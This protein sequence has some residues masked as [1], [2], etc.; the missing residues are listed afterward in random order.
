MS[1]RPNLPKNPLRR[2]GVSQRQRLTSALSPNGANAVQVDERNLADFLVL[3]HRLSPQVRYHR[4]PGAAAPASADDHWQGFFEAYTPVQIALISKTQTRTVKREYDG[5]LG[6]FLKEDVQ[7]QKEERLRDI[8][9]LWQTEI[10]KPID[11][12][13]KGLESYTPLRSVIKGLINTNLTET[14]ALILSF[15][16]AH[17]SGQVDFYLPFIDAFGLPLTPA[18]VNMPPLAPSLF[19]PTIRDDLDGIFQSLFQVY[20]QIIDQAPSYLATSLSARRDH[21]PHLALYI[22]M[23]DVLQPARDDLNRMTQRHLDFFYRRVLALPARPATP[24]YVHLLF[25]L[26]KPQRDYK[27]AAGTRFKAGKDATGVELFYSLDQ[28]IVIHKATIASLK[29]LFLESKEFPENIPTNVVKLL[30]SPV[31]NSADGLGAEFPK[32]QAVKAWLPFGGPRVSPSQAAAVSQGNAAQL[33]V[34]ISSDILLLQEDTRTITLELTLG[35]V[36]QSPKNLDTLKNA[37][38]VYLSG[39]KEWIVAKA[40]ASSESPA[41]PAVIKSVTWEQEDETSIDAILEIVVTLAAEVDPVLPYDTNNPIPFDP[42]TPNLPLTLDR[43]TPVLRL[44]LTT[45]ALD[46][47]G[48]SA[49]HYF[50]SVTLQDIKLTVQVPKVRNLVVQTDAGIQDITKPFQPFGPRPKKGANLYIGSQEVFGKHLTALTLNLEPEV[51]PPS[52]WA[53]YYLS[54]DS[55]HEATDFSPEIVTIASLR[56][57]IWRSASTDTNFLSSSTIDLKEELANLSLNTFAKPEAVEMFTSDSQNGFLRLQLMGNFLHDEYPAVLAR[58]VLAAATTQPSPFVAGKR[59]AIKGAYYQKGEEPAFLA[60]TRSV[61]P[62]A[63]A[64]FPKEPY[65]PVI[66]SLS[67]SY[68][69]QAGL[70]DCHL[71]QLYPFGGFKEISNVSSERLLPHFIHEGELFIGIADLDPPTALPLLIQVAEETADTGLRRTEDFRPMW[72]YLRDNTWVPLS[73]RIS[74]DTTNGLIRSGIINLGIPEDI[75]KANTTIL[76]PALHWV[77]VSMPARTPTVCHIIG[78]HPQAARVT[79]VDADNDPNHLATALPVGTIAKLEKPQAAIKGI[80]QPYPS[81]DGRVQEPPSQFY[82]RVSEHLR[83]KGR[84]VAIL[85]YER[86]VL[87]NFPDI[88]KVRCLNHGQFDDA[89]NELFEVAPGAVTLAVVPDLSQRATIDDLQPKVNINRLQAIETYLTSRS[90]SWTTIKVVNPQ[91]EPIR[92]SFEVQFRAP[93][94][95]NFGYYCRELEQ[96]IVGFLTP[97]TLG[98]EA[99]IHFGG[100]VYR[101]AILNFVEELDYVDYVV[102]FKMFHN[103]QDDVREALASTARSVLTSVAPN[104]PTGHSIKPYRKPTAITPNPPLET[105][106]LGYEPLDNLVLGPDDPEDPNNE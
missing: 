11:T 79:F 14:I 94:D 15:E 103:G 87:E 98:Q 55:A 7:G 24:D 50:R 4:L 78:I 34:A 43:P 29:G 8:L 60:E 26:V 102:N 25:E 80:E 92:V 96:A 47:E 105:G 83:H 64:V 76:D 23:L 48:R 81:I 90:S 36:F 52:D 89:T 22:A 35:S 88:Y 106:I 104:H 45:N 6:L 75:S 61:D 51:P 53:E 95:A 19:S 67:L 42:D 63:E 101:S 17:P 1:Q 84:A 32:E 37:F 46:A 16:Q 73:D 58:Q 5:L 13:Y 91:Y 85:D 86:L 57:R 77:K 10:L 62:Q 20:R 72:F 93:F 97:W 74:S 41:A 9:L 18:A 66:R 33:G 49:Y 3:A 59:L 100:K 30:T 31:A 99:D 68:A 27:L 40:S 56:Q 39:E 82:T 21:P 2:A 38:E 70:S 69:A 54:Y 71:F 65:T 12:W 28:D 44:Q